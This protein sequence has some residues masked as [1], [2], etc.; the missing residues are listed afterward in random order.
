MET[1]NSRIFSIIDSSKD[2][3]DTKMAKYLGCSKSTVSRWRHEDI[4]PH[5]KYTGAIAEYLG[6]SVNYLLKGENDFDDELE[7][8]VEL[9]HRDKRYRVLLDSSSKLNGEALEQLIAFIDKINS[10]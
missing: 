5:S 2:L 6:V 3:S 10:K 4:T 8:C 7:A 1:I 9:L